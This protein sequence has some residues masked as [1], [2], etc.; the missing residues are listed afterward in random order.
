MSQ[1]AAQRLQF[2]LL[3]V[4]CCH[5]NVATS[6]RGYPKRTVLLSSENQFP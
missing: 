2:Q 3:L 1:I 6:Q 4:G 5:H